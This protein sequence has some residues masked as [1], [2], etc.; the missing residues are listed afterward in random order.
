MR[1]LEQ[2]MRFSLKSLAVAAALVTTGLGISV[3]PAAAR[4]HA[5]VI[6]QEKP[7]HHVRRYHRDYRRPVVVRRDHYDRG[8]HYGRDRH[9]RYDRRHDVRIR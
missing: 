8:R 3:A 1:L 9:H 4:S 2:L 6:V 7:V 5:V